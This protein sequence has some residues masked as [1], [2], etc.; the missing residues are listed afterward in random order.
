MEQN[1]FIL[2]EE[3][4]SMHVRTFTLED[5]IGNFTN[6][7]PYR[8]LLVA[9]QIMWLKILCTVYILWTHSYIT[10]ILFLAIKYFTCYV[11]WW[12]KW[13]LLNAIK[14]K[15]P[16]QHFKRSLIKMKFCISACCEVIWIS[17]VTSNTPDQ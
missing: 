1:D 11:Q 10:L 17:S 5:D 12:P 14:L 2:L 6:K 4:H 15:G 3:L 16:Y 13:D 9:Y 8:L 7:L